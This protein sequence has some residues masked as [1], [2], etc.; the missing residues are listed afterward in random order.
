MRAPMKRMQSI[1]AKLTVL[2]QSVN[3]LS[4][5]FVKSDA[6]LNVWYLRARSS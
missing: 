3:V 5:F 6:G 1:G 4:T 2:R